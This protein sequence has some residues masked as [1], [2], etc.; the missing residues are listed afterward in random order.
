MQ[1]LTK[2]ITYSLVLFISSAMAQQKLEKVS[3]SIN[4]NDDVVIDL[5]TSYTNLEI[6]TW[7]RDIIEIEAYIESDKLSETELRKFLE[8]WGLDI[9]ASKSKVSIVTLGELGS[10]D[11]SL[12]LFDDSYTDA[13]RVMEMELAEIPIVEPLLESLLLSEMPPVPDMPEIPSVPPLPELPE[14]MAGKGFDY[15]KYQKEGEAY[16]EKWGEEYGEKYGEEY[17]RKMEAWAKEWENSPKM[18]EFEKKMEAWGE[19]FGEEFGEKF[20]KEMAAWGERF[21]KQMEQ[22]AKRIEERQA[23]FEKRHKAREQAIKERQEHAE[24][25]MKA[26]QKANEAR[27][28]ARIQQ[29]NGTNDGIKKTIKIKMPKKAKLNINVRHGEL[30]FAA[31]I[32]NVKA[33]L[34]HTALLASS[35]DGSNT[36]IN[37]SYAPVDITTWEAG[38]LF[39]NFVEQA[40]INQAN[41]LVLSANS[42]N[43]DLGTIKGNAIIDGSFGDLNIGNIDSGF[44]NINITLEN[45]D[46]LL[47]LPETDFN[48]QYKGMHSRLLHPQNS[49]NDNVASF[50]TGNLSSYKTIVVNAKFSEVIMQ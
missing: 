18:K 4:V 48:L 22:K 42:S 20:E 45:S 11:E 35:I 10:W 50:S 38:E 9:D 15:D 12:V 36:S 28:K 26:R 1:F 3:Q 40:S 14:G 47:R 2:I 23:A 24:V 17:A 44:N 7:N 30:K 46:A 5:N 43:I 31:N 34:S 37:V 49:N 33:N 21:E 19:K 27:R 29:F 41:R 39:L 6:D 32:N 16:L 13:L 8:S 25:R